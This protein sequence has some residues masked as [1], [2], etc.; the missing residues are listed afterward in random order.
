MNALTNNDLTPVPRLYHYTQLNLMWLILQGQEIW[1]THAR[2]SNDDEELK[3]GWSFFSKLSGQGTST[4]D[5]D[6]INPFVVCFC[7]DGD[8]LS[9]WRAYA[10]DGVAI[11][12]AFPDT[13]D[14]TMLRQKRPSDEAGPPDLT[15]GIVQEQLRPYPVLYLDQWRGQDQPQPPELLLPRQS[16][17]K[18]APRERL[19]KRRVS[20]RLETLMLSHTDGAPDRWAWAVESLTPFVKDS[21]FAEEVEWR[22]V[23]S[24][25]APGWHDSVEYHHHPDLPTKRPII[26]LGWGKRP[27]RVAPNTAEAT[28]EEKV[29][30]KVRVH[31]RIIDAWNRNDTTRALDMN[32]E[33]C[34]G[35]A[36]QVT[37]QS[38]SSSQDKP[39]FGVWVGPEDSDGKVFAQVEAAL[40]R[41]LPADFGH[42]GDLRTLR[43][44]VQIWYDGAWPIRSIRVGPH[45]R[46]EEVKEAIAHY[47]STHWQ[48]R[49]V[50][51]KPSRIPYR[52]PK[53]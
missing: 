29:E 36:F 53:T 22:L 35:T 44:L 3:S 16:N 32:S 43:G 39:P 28:A 15:D 1:A 37:V 10:R 24:P 27:A 31:Q 50:T 40:A 20:E 14:L 23:V 11:E 47:L 17:P 41:L 48:F 21:G 9:Q 33:F 46:V 18:A 5:L 2:F 25:K 4:I 45:P 34:P 19:T 52:P 26:R 38:E 6:T 49:Y 8:L 51:V 30:V 7:E 12:F 42:D 13:F